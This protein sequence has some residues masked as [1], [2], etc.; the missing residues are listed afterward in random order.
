MK[1][2]VYDHGLCS[3]A[4]ITLKRAGHSVA[5][6][7][8]WASAFPK[9]DSIIGLDLD[10]LDRVE[11]FSTVLERCDLVACFDTFSQ[12]HE[13]Q[14]LKSGKPVWGAR[15]AEILE[16]DRI[17]MKTLQEKLKLPTQP[18]T[19]VT[20]ISALITYLKANK[21]KWVKTTGK[22]RGCVETFFH[23]EWDETRNIELGQLIV[24]FGPIGDSIP[25]LI[26]DPVGECEPGWDGFVVAGEYLSP[27]MI[28]YED[29]DE[30]YIG[31]VTSVFPT[32]IHNITKNLLPLFKSYDS[33]SLVSFE[34]RIDEAHKGYLIDP[35]IR[36]P[37]PPLAVELE[38]FT[39]FA[40]IITNGAKGNAIAVK[41]SAKY[42]AAIEI[43]SDWVLNHWTHLDFPQANRQLIKLQK[44]CCVN[45][46]YWAL[47]GSF[48]VA[49]CVG[50]GQTMQ[51]AADQAMKVASEF[52]CKGMY[53]DEASLQCLIDKTIPEGIEY[54]IPF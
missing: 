44:A 18:W 32:P 5:Y 45:G 11:N 25:F 52:R 40:E 38:T 28:G 4:A 22:H 41:S 8:P 17:H 2:L 46:R 10:G 47:P 39:N 9:M 49:T 37:H 51:A 19:T 24:D 42:G 21:N 43:K 36:A 33:S 3:E 1:I 35:C 29:K 6:F 50:T 13:Q 14:A 30:T 54:G 16:Q 27:H 34:V 48:V 31:H 53:Y 12:D 23:T 15:G 7:T 20:G 26:E